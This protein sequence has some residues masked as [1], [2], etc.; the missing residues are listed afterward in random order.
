MMARLLKMQ[1]IIPSPQL[2]P[3]MGSS[4]DSNSS[5]GEGVERGRYLV[6]ALSP[7]LYI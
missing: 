3:A 7:T 2:S 5:A 4:Y 6:F 1:S